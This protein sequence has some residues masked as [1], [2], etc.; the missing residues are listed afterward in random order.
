M[1]EYSLGSLK[2]NW[3]AAVEPRTPS[4]AIL[5]YRVTAVFNGSWIKHVPTFIGKYLRAENI[6]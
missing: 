6:D 1:E 3:R 2:T 5:F 4:W